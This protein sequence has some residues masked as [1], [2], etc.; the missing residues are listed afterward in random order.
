MRPEPTS[1]P[2]LLS[3]RELLGDSMAG[4]AGIALAF[5]LGR[6]AAAEEKD[7]ALAALHF[8][9][10]A[11]RVIQIFAAGGV[12]HVDT[13][14]YKPE[15]ENLHGKEMTGKGKVDTFFARPGFLMKSPFDFKQRGKSGL[16]VSNLLPKMAEHADDLWCDPLE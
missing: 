3:R 5:M 8:P 16:W 7:G 2:G 15:L 14:D 10:K 11:K 4:M 12:S 6:E 1:A 13:F 9:P